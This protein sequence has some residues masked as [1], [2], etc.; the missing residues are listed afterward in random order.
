M[1]L[2]KELIL[3]ILGVTAILAVMIV[4]LVIPL[5]KGIRSSSQDF[6]ENRK[7]VVNLQREKR[8][9]IALKQEYEDSKG[10]F[11]KINSL[12]V[13]SEVPVKFIE[14]LE[15][16]SVKANF[17]IEVSPGPGTQSKSDLWPTIF[18]KVAGSGSFTDFAKF[19]E[20]VENSPFLVEVQDLNVDRLTEEDVRGESKERKVGDV[21]AKILIKAYTNQ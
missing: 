2:N 9:Y 1:N 21:E 19:L 7:K 14:F 6:V 11:E 20:R 18:F 12:F 13:N 3:Y 10:K 15:E 4:F 17:P 5:I 8:H 16:S